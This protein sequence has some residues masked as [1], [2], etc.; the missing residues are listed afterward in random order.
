M[1]IK[2]MLNT[3]E[4]RKALQA[5]I[6]KYIN[7]PAPPQGHHYL[8]TPYD[9]IN[10][11]GELTV[12]ALPALYIEVVEKRS[13]LPSSQRSAITGIVNSALF[14]AHQA[15]QEK[16]QPENARSKRQAAKQLASG[17]TPPADV[18]PKRKH[19]RRKDS[20]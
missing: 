9:A 2:E 14:A 15:M 20:E 1:T 12:E 19:T 7:R 3:D 13:K 5:D 6:D 8:R 10:E 16:Q 18:M 17:V 11:R 4:F